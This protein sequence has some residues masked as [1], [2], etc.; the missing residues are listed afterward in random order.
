MLPRTGALTVITCPS[1]MEGP[2]KVTGC[3]GISA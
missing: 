1:A 2:V 3:G